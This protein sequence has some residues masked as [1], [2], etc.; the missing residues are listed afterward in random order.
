[1]EPRVNGATFHILMEKVR[2][3]DGL[4]DGAGWGVCLSKESVQDSAMSQGLKV[5]VARGKSLEAEGAKGALRPVMYNHRFE[6]VCCAETWFIPSLNLMVSYF[7]N[8]THTLRRFGGCTHWGGVF[9]VT[10]MIMG[11]PPSMGT[12]LHTTEWTHNSH[13]HTLPHS[14]PCP[15]SHIT[16]WHTTITFTLT[17]SH[18]H[19]STCDHTLTY[20]TNNTHTLTHTHMYTHTHT[21]TLTNTHTN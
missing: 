5:D 21:H 9:S 11:T 17:H 13:T 7:W 14:H 19:S 15:L 2:I 3:L 12:P 4:E 1:M 18:A 16:H 10:W 8:K 6:P 20:T